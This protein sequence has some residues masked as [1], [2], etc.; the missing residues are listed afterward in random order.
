L[1]FVDL[2]KETGRQWRNLLPQTRE[3]LEAEARLQKEGYDEQ[4]Q[5]YQRSTEYQTH[6]QYLDEFRGQ[7][8]KDSVQK[9]QGMSGHQEESAGWKDASEHSTLVSC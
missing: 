5:E 3:T 6:R 2:A 8:T 9:P 1:E 4:L 7:G